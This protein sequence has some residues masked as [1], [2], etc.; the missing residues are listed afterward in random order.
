MDGSN[1][2][3]LLKLYKQKPTQLTSTP[4]DGYIYWVDAN[5]GTLQK[6]Q[7]DGTR[8][9]FVWTDIGQPFGMAV[10]DQ[11]IF[12]SDVFEG[13]IYRCNIHSN[14]NQKRLQYIEKSN[15]TPKGIVV[16]SAHRNGG[17]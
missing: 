15:A 2:E 16:V 17:Q 8:Y 1:I 10:Y 11:S 12:W 5:K 13:T 7:Y 3:T 6:I 9:E 14:T 4:I